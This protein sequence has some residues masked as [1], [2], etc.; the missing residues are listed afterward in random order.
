MMTSHLHD[1]NA[2]KWNMRIML[3]SKDKILIKTYGNLK[4]FLPED[5][6]RS[7]L[8]I[9]K[10]W[11]SKHRITFCENC[12]QPVWLKALQEAIGRY[13]PQLQTPLLQLAIEHIIKVQL[14]I[15]Y[16]PRASDALK[17]FGCDVWEHECQA[18]N[19]TASVQ[20]DHFLHGNTLP[21]L[22]ATDLINKR[23]VHHVLPKLSPCLKKPLRR[24][25]NSS[26]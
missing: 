14:Q 6:S 10:K 20:C 18:S 12:A 16:R 23:I 17:R 4:D 2:T 22:F 3:L 1:N 26:V 19:V 7:T 15:S 13:H 24:C 11:K 9:Y 8:T 5:W 25:R 21:V